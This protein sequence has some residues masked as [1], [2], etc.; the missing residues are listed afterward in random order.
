MNKKSVGIAIIVAAVIIAA[1][2][3]LFN[4]QFSSKNQSTE[5]SGITVSNATSAS[6]PTNAT[7]STPI[8]RHITVQLNESM[9][10]KANP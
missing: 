4:N 6:Q 1:A 10:I 5:G 8:G 3:V 2:I 7:V 9:K